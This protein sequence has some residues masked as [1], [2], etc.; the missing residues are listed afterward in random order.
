[1]EQNIAQILET[2][3][4]LPAEARAFLAG[5]LI[6]S[7]EETVESDAEAAW[8]AEVL[9]R[10]EELDNAVVEPVPWADA[11]RRISGA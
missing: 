7:L 6:E 1:M 4:K 3:L 10:V 9:K 11:R 2:V 5:S 8:E